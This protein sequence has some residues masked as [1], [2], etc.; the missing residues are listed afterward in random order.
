MQVALSRNGVIYNVIE[1]ESV[2][3]AQALFPDA[4]AFEAT[5]IGIGWR[6]SNGA[7][8]PPPATP[9]PGQPPAP[10]VP[11][12]V[13]FGVFRVIDGWVEAVGTASGF[14]FVFAMGPGLY[15]LIFDEPQPD[16]SYSAYPSSS[17]GQINIP[18]RTIDELHVTISNAAGE[19][20][21]ADEFSVQVVR[22]R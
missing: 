22:S 14:S 13:A 10:T 5:G 8:S 19:L 2:A 20:V 21:D 9:D 3:A 12:V 17:S 6:E 4:N 15:A 7:W 1:A 11:T 16:L 18:T